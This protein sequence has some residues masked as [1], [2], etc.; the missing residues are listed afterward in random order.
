MS[1]IIHLLPDS[2]ANQIAAGEVI[3]RPASVVKELV[4]NAI[5]AG[6]SMVKVIV[7]D[8]GRTLVQVIDDGC[9]MTETDA[10]LAFERHATSKIREATDLYQLH[11]MGFR[12]EALASIAAVAQ[13][14][15]LT[16]RAADE[17]GVEIDISG[18]K[19]TNQQ[20]IACAIGSNFSVKNLFFNIPAR[21]RFLKSDA[22]EMRHLSTEFLRVALA[23]PNVTLSLS[24]NGTPIFTLPAG[25]MRQ[26]V[27]AVAGRA[28]SQEL[29]PIEIETSLV[30]ISGFIGTP[31][32]AK[33]T[34]GDQYFFAN[35][36]FMK[37]P[38]LHRAVMDAYKN[39]ISSDV[40]PAYFI[41]ITV[42]P[43]CL[44]VNVHPQKTEIK[45]DNDTAIWQI[46]NAGVRE[47]LGKFNITP[48]LDFEN[49]PTIDIP[50][51]IPSQM[52]DADVQTQF[53][54]D[55]IAPY[56][57]FEHES[58][59]NDLTSSMKPFTPNMR[60]TS[61]NHTSQNVDGWEKIYQ[62][63]I[64]AEER[65]DII[66]SRIGTDENQTTFDFAS[67][68]DEIRPAVNFSQLQGKYIIG[69][70]ENGIII[71]DQRRAHERLQYDTLAN[72]VDEN[73]CAS[74]QLMFPEYIPIGAEDACIV[75]EISGELERSGFIVKYDESNGQLE[76]SSIPAIM[77][78]S[79][80]QGIIESLIYDFRNG[81]VDVCGGVMEYVTRILAKHSAIPY[82]KVLSTDEMNMMYKKLFASSSPSLTPSGKKIFTI[83]TTTDIESKF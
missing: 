69:Y 5:D 31:E 34:G 60:S 59:D 10:R 12:G 35:D 54:P 61:Y 83:I 49:V 8:A 67:S 53:D 21:R 52:V 56:N 40:T 32:T 30:K 28:L 43:Q 68:I 33:K 65:N 79:C 44:D 63:V 71:I 48:S 19:I 26:R 81:E 15:L 17:L 45:F 74:Q 80:I 76:V 37:H 20:P 62:S 13:V 64:N 75:E 46:L 73:R 78:V 82:G 42:E 55:N 9:G 29:L 50:T 22:A 57:P 14:E 2:V 11:T 25:N 58:S 7:K 18:S 27:A 41:Y 39:I 36:R 1:N 23:H 6:A 38:Y 72:M 16:R 24:S 70:V 47:C 66:E 4:E 77:D 3:Q 51:Y